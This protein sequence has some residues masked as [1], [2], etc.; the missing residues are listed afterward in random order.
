MNQLT[1]DE[2][3]TIVVETIERIW[4][5]NDWTLAEE[6]YVPDVIA[7]VPFQ[8]E[9]LRGREAFRAF[10]ETLHKTFPDWRAEIE[11]TV[12]E[13]DTVAMR[14]TVRGTNLGSWGSLPP[15]RRSFETHEALFARLSPEG[16]GVE[17]WFFVDEFGVARQLGLA[18]SGPPPKVLVHAMLFV[19]RLRARLRNK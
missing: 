14:W 10:H 6:R 2:L 12:V 8:K 3:R 13:G 7:H 5:G 11:H 16:R 4:N 17:F 9:P 1:P 19:Q 15:T 18:P